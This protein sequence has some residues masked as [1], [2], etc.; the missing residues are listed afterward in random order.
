MAVFD[1]ADCYCIGH[2]GVFHSKSFW[3]VCKGFCCPPVHAAHLGTAS[4]VAAEFFKLGNCPL[5]CCIVGTITRYG[6][7]ATVFFGDIA[8]HSFAFGCTQERWHPIWRTSL[9]G[10]FA[11]D[12]GQDCS[13]RF[14]WCAW[15]ELLGSCALELSWLELLGS[16]AL[17]WIG[18]GSITV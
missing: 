18:V 16:C 13:A 9:A 15:L 14:G 6:Y 4:F 11:C 17:E 12:G 2:I 7:E 5:F 10:L 1:S 3:I 8:Y